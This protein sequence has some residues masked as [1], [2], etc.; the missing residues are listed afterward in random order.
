MLGK[1]KSAGS[2][3][4]FVFTVIQFASAV[5]GEFLIAVVIAAYSRTQVGAL[6]TNL[7]FFCFLWWSE[8]PHPGILQICICLP[9]F[10]SR[11]QFCP[12]ISVYTGTHRTQVLHRLTGARYPREYVRKKKRSDNLFIGLFWENQRSYTEP[13]QSIAARS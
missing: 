10:N 8:M 4:L 2:H 1:R 9:F 12:F 13:L 3:Y 5:K 6:A 7:C 11:Y